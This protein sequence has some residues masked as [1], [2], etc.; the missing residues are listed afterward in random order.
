M[1]EWKI[2]GLSF[3]KD[4]GILMKIDCVI[5]IEDFSLS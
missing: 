5:W 2:C 3:N 1:L 4:G